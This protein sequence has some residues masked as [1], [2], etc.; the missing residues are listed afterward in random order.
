MFVWGNYMSLVAFAT[1][2]TAAV[3][4]RRRPESTAACC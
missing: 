4:A 2:V 3:I 1:L